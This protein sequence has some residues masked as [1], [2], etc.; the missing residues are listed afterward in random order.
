M[1][2]RR[3]KL[4]PCTGRYTPPLAAPLL[5]PPPPA[6]RLSRLPRPAS[7]PSGSESSSGC[8]ACGWA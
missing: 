5:L 6:S 7:A 8:G 2:G 4:H 1:S 3:C